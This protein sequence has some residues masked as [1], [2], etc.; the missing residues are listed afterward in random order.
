[1]IK[2]WQLFLEN[3]NF[4]ESEFKKMGETLKM[5]LIKTFEKMYV[6]EWILR[7]SGVN[8]DE[9][10]EYGVNKI[11]EVILISFDEILES[12]SEFSDDTKDML[13]DALSRSAEKAKTIMIK[14]SFQSGISN[15]VDEF[16]TIIIEYKKQMGTEGE[17]WKQEKEVDYEKLSPSELDKYINQAIDDR[18]FKKLDYL[19]K[20]I[21]ESVDTL[22]IDI[23]KEVKEICYQMAKQLFDFCLKVLK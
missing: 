15:L 2:N 20:F 14:E 23:E 3:E 5:S 16:V 10:L 12:N 18:D 21:K 19:R 6:G 22:P 9:V 13:M 4:D 1:M 11:L 8:V 17:E 7:S